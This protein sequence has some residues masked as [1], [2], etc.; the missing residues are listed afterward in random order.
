MKNKFKIPLYAL[1]FIA[2]SIIIAIPAFLQRKNFSEIQPTFTIF[3]TTTTTTSPTT[4]TTSY[5]QPSITTSSITRTTQ[6]SPT[7]VKHTATKISTTTT[8][9]EITTTNQSSSSTSKISPSTIIT[10]EGTTSS[11][12]ETQCTSCNCPTEPID[13]LPSWPGQNPEQECIN[14]GCRW[15]PNNIY[16][17]YCIVGPKPSNAECEIDNSLKKSCGYFG[18][19]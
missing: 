13:C 6:N 10:T 12:T 3:S 1:F 18:I 19:W 7:T 17:P 5:V 4:K 2:L 15:C 9:A 16:D 14:R 11:K 8:P